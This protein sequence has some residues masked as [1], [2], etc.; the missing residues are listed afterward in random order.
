M[1]TGC[2]VMLQTDERKKK[3][4]GWGSVLLAKH[5]SQQCW[6]TKGTERDSC[7]DHVAR[8]RKEAELGGKGV[9]LPKR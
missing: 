9:Q 1:R 5:T 7:V 6:G 4:V 2:E 3:G 8:P